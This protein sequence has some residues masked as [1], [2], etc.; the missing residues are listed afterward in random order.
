MPRS[1]H[2]VDSNGD[3][4][5]EEGD[6][7]EVDDSDDESSEILSIDNEDEELHSCDDNSNVIP[8]GD[9]T[10]DVYALLAMPKKRLASNKTDIKDEESEGKADKR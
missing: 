7:H 3:E 4:S 9:T 2:E 1:S 5:Q 8:D 6:M 10:E